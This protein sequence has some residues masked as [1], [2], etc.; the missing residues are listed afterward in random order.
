MRERLFYRLKP[1]TSRDG[2]TMR[3]ED[4]R[5]RRRDSNPDE[6][7]GKVLRNRA[8]KTAE[9]YQSRPIELAAFGSTKVKVGK[10]R[11]G[12]RRAWKTDDGPQC[13]VDHELQSADGAEDAMECLPASNFHIIYS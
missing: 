5:M 3:V 7:S 9:H 2:R 1:V 11:T 8:L 4:E 13:G 12:V 10:R 6:V